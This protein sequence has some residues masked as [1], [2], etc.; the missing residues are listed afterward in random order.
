MPYKKVLFFSD[1][2][3]D[4]AHVLVNTV[5]KNKSKDTVK[6]YTDAHKAW[7]IQT[8]IGHPSTNDYINYVQKILIPNFPITKADILCT[9][10]ILG[11]NVGTIKGKMTRK[12]PER[13]TIGSSD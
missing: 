7:L 10:D 11:L 5:D 2:K 8:V 13:G 6:Q 3:R 9:E 4:T 1:V 12:M